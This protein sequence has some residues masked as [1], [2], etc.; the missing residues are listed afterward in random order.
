MI[1]LLNRREAQPLEIPRVVSTNVGGL[2]GRTPSEKD[3]EKKK[4]AA[5]LSAN[6]ILLDVVVLAISWAENSCVVC[7]CMSVGTFAEQLVLVLN[8]ARL[9]QRR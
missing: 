8:P 3:E 4:K 7:T 1:C 2:K 5:G 9:Q 6:S